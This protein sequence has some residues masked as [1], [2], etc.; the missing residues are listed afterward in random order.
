MRSI[1]VILVLAISANSFSQEKELA[2]KKVTEAASNYINTFYKADT[3]LAYKS[4]HPKLRKVGWWFNN[5]KDQYSNASEM[6]FDR[7]ISLAKRWNVKGD[8]ANEKSIHEVEILDVCD[9]IAV[10]KV[11]AVWGIDYLNMVNTREG[12]KIINIV[13]QSKPK[14]STRE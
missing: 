4:V 10:A 2:V 12:W 3:T 1:I 8:R 9:K 13:W 6:S 14:F 7:L 11:T 5:K